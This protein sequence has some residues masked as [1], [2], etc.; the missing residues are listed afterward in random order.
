MEVMPPGSGNILLG[1]SPLRGMFRFGPLR[2]G[3]SVQIELELH[4]VMTEDDVEKIRSANWTSC[5]INEA[6]EVDFEVLHIGWTR[7]GRFPSAD[8]GGCTWRTI[9]MDYN[10]PPSDHWLESLAERGTI[11]LGDKSFEIAHFRQPPAA[12]KVV[13]DDGR[14][15]Y[16]L[17]PEAENLENLKDGMGFYAGAIALERLNGRD[18]AVD[19]LYCLLD[20]DER[21]GRPVWP[22]FT[23][24]RHVAKAP[25]EPVEGLPVFAGFDTSGLHP[26]A[27]FAQCI[28]RRWCVLDET[29]GDG[30]GFQEFLEGSIMPI[31]KGRYGSS[32][33]TFACDPSNTRD[34][35]AKVAPSE[36]LASKGFKVWAKGTNSVS[37]RIEAVAAMLNQDAGGLLVSPTCQY[38][39][40]A[41]LG[42]AD[43]DGYHYEKVRARSS[44]GEAW[45]TEPAKNDAS[46]LADALQYLA[47]YVGL[48][49]RVSSPRV[50]RALAEAAARS[51]RGRRKAA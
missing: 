3:T 33:I 29:Y 7:T 19:R 48:G 2:D 39:V 27:V 42:K 35:W 12:F 36:R 38:L 49:D 51:R 11:F 21:G 41:M 28:D 40:K 44:F 20:T 47:L 17:N 18:D 8:G 32:E 5:W 26:G 24:E 46:H 34:Q 22:M 37:T 1:D 10:R 43:K 14:V 13:G 50:R 9:L 23:K 6:T 25:I 4:A 45:K 30:V 16:V 31:C 15:D